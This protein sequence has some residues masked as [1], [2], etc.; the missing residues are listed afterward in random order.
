MIKECLKLS[1]SIVNGGRCA[2]S[3]PNLTTKCGYPSLVNQKTI[4][5]R[6][7]AKSA[8]PSQTNPPYLPEYPTTTQE[9]DSS[10]KLSANAIVAILNM[11]SFL[12][13]LD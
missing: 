5:N 3:I 2:V 9:E 11:N 13:F 12:E 7:I 10:N 6:A 1:C 4:D 8:P